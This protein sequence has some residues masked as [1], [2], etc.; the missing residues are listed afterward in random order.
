MVTMLILPRDNLTLCLGV[1]GTICKATMEI[2][3]RLGDIS[4]DALNPFS[5]LSDGGTKGS[6]I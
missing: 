1:R 6:F 2:E 3:V 5:T 4:Y